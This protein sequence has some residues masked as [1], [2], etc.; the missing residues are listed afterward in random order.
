MRPSLVVVYAPLLDDH[1]GFA[2]ALE[3][4]AIEAFIPELDIERLAV[5]ILP[6]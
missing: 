2:Q 6:R 5:A 3:D 1:L 4:F